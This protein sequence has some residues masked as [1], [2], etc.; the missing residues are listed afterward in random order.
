MRRFQSGLWTHKDFVRL[1]SA[2]SISLFGSLITRTALAF[3][4]ILTLHA[5]A[6]QIALLGIAEMAPAFLLSLFAGAWVDRLPRRPIMIVSDLV[7]AVLLM[8]VPIAA[9]FDALRIEHLYVIAGLTS[10]FSVFFDL[11]YQAYLPSLVHSE[12]LVEGNSKL[13]AS[14]AVSETAAFSLGGWLVEIMTA[15]GAIVIDAVSFLA[16]AYFI[17]RI[18]SPETAPKP[19][20]ERQHIRVEITDGIRM[21]SR[22]PVLRSLAVSNLMLQFGYRVNGVVYLLFVTRELGFKPGAL[23]LIFAVGGISSLAG[24]IFAQR[25]TLWLGIGPAMIAG[26]VLTGAGQGLIALATG[27]SVLTVIMLVAQQ[28]IADSGATVY[29][30]DELSLRQAIAPATSLGRING[31]MRV[32]EFGAMLI[33]ALL[34]GWLG[35]A[36]GLR[37]TV[38]FASTSM[39]LGA[40]WLACTPVRRLRSTPVP[41][42]EA[43]P[44]T[45]LVM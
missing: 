28:V 29:I 5:N 21:L 41:L 36:V 23:G 11:A 18:E 19:K 10:I 45:Q 20:A 14:A 17:H 31:S 9:L 34:G 4:A 27:V 12:E 15:P 16:S 13:A 26:L 2:E 37:F 3:A 32:L 6:F 44:E 7:R 8:T 43:L 33:G 42:V 35:S 40:V 25:F 39:A 38:I 24:S 30:I 1:W 22:E